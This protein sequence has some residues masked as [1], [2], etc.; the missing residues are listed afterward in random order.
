MS[1]VKM[2]PTPAKFHYIFNLR[3]LSRIWQG[4]LTIK[5]EECSNLQTLLALFKHEC[6]RVIADRFVSQEDIF[7]F[8]SA[9]TRAIEK[10]IG[11]GMAGKVHEEPYFVD[12]LRDMPDPTG[13]EPEDFVF[14]VPKVY[15]MVHHNIAVI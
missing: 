11:R 12:F 3:D 2:L 14:V 1:E 15:E 8:E 5:A 6:T 13:D 7:W 10:V 4:M 9:I